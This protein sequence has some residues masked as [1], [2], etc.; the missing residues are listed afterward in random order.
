MSEAGQCAHRWTD[1]LALHV[2]LGLGLGLILSCGGVVAP[3]AAAAFQAAAPSCQV[4]G[5]PVVA[6]VPWPQRRYD[7]VA[8]SQIS[9]GTGVTVAVIDSGVDARHPQLT[10]RVREGTDLIDPGR[11]GRL[12]CVGHGTAI[13]SIIAARPVAGSG[14]R[15]LAPGADIVPIRASERVAVDGVI[16]GEGTIADVVAGVRAAV[17]HDVQVINL[18]LSTTRDDSRLRRA[19]RAAIEADIVVVAAV[20]NQHERGDPTPYP[21]AYPG[22]VGVGAVSSDGLRVA[23]SQVGRYVDIVA[24]GDDVIAAA[25]GRGHGSYQG[26]SY[27]APFVAATAALIRARWP[28]LNQAAVVRRLLATADPAAGPLPSAEYGHGVLNPMRALTEIVPSSAATESAPA[29]ASTGLAAASRPARAG[30]PSGI[31]VAV[32]VSLILAA[33]GIGAV[34]AV[35]PLGRR[36]RWH[37]GR[38]S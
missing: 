10:G 11:D 1:R 8:L 3:S 28:G 19:I 13:A 37:P 33:T 26:T 38:S 29:P 12:D 30:T 14:L 35:T 7:L 36:R 32:A 25:A 24:P 2:F 21:A 4:N 17:A 34:A 5:S 6:D 16:S 23:S 9:D 22:V 31:A 15:G 18:S 20:G 27:A